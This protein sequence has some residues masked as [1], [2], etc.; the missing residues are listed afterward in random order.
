MASNIQ[1]GNSVY[2]CRSRL[3]T[4]PDQGKAF[5]QSTV[6]S[7]NHR[8]I[9]IMMPNGT[10]SAL[11]AT[12]FAHHRVGIAII[13]FGDFASEY[14]LLNPLAKTILQYCRLLFGDDDYVTLFKIRSLA[15]LSCLCESRSFHPFE[16][17]VVI[18]HGSISGEIG[19]A[20]ECIDVGMAIEQFEKNSPQ[21]WDFTF[22]CCYLGR[23]VF[24]KKFSLSGCCKSMIAPFNSV[25]GA[26]S[27]QFVQTYLIKT[28]L[29]GETTAIAHRHASESTP[30]KSAFRL[31]RNGKHIA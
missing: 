19:A 20:V 23:Q 16:H 4:L 28:L 9:A 6:V 31:W 12:K 1:V 21:A 27:A 10:H 22:L 25:H 24:A 29:E 30:P 11:I 8:S 15:E 13:V 14:T 5:Y 18:G 2:V 7:K 17:I 3:P 26:V